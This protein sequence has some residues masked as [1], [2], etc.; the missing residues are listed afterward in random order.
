[1]AFALAVGFGCL[2]GLCFG[3]FAWRNRPATGKANS[4]G[5]VTLA[6]QPQEWCESA[7]CG[8]SCAIVSFIFIRIGELIID[9]W[10]FPLLSFEKIY[11]LCT[12]H[13]PQPIEPIESITVLESMQVAISHIPISHVISASPHSQ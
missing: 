8:M 1:M 13:S 5:I 10:L 3:T 4:L 7:K 2:L 11:L 12:V 9:L 6:V